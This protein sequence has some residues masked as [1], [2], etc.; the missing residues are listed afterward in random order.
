MSVGLVG[1]PPR[2]SA[3]QQRL[4]SSVLGVVQGFALRMVK[5]RPALSREELV[6]VGNQAAVRAAFA[7]KPER[8]TFE[9]FAA[10]W[11]WAEMQ[12]EAR[13][14]AR[15]WSRE[16]LRPHAGE[17][18]PIEL[19]VEE[20]GAELNRAL[21]ATA[22]EDRAK[23]V[24]ETQ[25]RAAGFAASI[26]LHEPADAS[27]AE[28]EEQMVGRLTLLEGKRWLDRVVQEMPE[29]ERWFFL[30]FYRDE[31]TLDAIGRELGGVKRTMQRLH[32]RVLRFL[33]DAMRRDL[34]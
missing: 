32:D 15:Q 8:G 34:L 11:I 27:Q 31:W 33:D 26:L 2:L 4:A 18:H 9:A 7:Y 29:Q 10:T 19:T 3:E 23:Q 13:K 6:S 1:G 14:M 17:Q 25:R 24:R 21:R 12:G 22:A 20:Q 16:V 5:R 30:R 28:G